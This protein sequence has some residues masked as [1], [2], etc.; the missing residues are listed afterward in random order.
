MDR[1]VLM[2]W[3]LEKKKLGKHNG[4]MR[5]AVIWLLVLA[6][7]G[8]AGFLGV[9]PLLHYLKQRNA[10]QWREAEVVRGEIVSV[11]NATGTIEPVRKVLVGSFASG[12][13][14]ELYVDYN[15]PVNQGD[16]LAEIDPQLYDATK[17]RDE[18]ALAT[19]RAEA[20]RVEALLEQAANDYDRAMALWL[21]N[22][23]FVSDTEIDR[24]K[25]NHLALRAQL[26][27]AEAAVARAQADL[28]NAR[29]QLEY[30]KIRSPVTGRVIER[31]VDKGQTVVAQF[32]TPDMFVVAPDMEKEIHVYAS[33]DEADIGLIRK[34]QE[35]DQPVY[36][37]VDAYPDDLFEGRIYQVRMNPKTTQ[38]VVTYPV[39]VAT[40]NPELKLLPG[41]TA[42]L[43]FQIET[44]KDVVKVPN[45]A[46]RFYPKPEQVRP[47][48]RAIIDT[49]EEQPAA[50]AAEQT[51]DRRSA[52]QRHAARAA[53]NRRH[54]WVA[55]GELL[56]AV[57][58]TVG[59]ADY[60][61]TEAVRGELA[62]GQKLVTGVK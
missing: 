46:L 5:A 38:N 32:Q 23:E 62:P 20:E 28:E 53:H 39:V 13:I 48:D 29:T 40:S 18:A 27:V 16:L 17:V 49:S 34:A 37:T 11:V 45:A 10:P 8:A 26:K 4:T 33:V 2:A 52:A 3:D 58:V 12:P 22:P 51:V 60:A 30:T 44:R 14:K 24:Y 55:E 42:D 9:P 50:S 43:S 31:K 35:S 61:H 59:L 56:R 47:E 1:V 19:A 36:F 15:S 21:E 41:M 7:L 25:Y 6:V 54:V 57:P